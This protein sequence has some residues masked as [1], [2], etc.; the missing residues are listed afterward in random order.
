MA[1]AT[2]APGAASGEAR[3]TVVAEMRKGRPCVSAFDPRV[4]EDDGCA[5]AARPRRQS[6]EPSG[7]HFTARARASHTRTRRADHPKRSKDVAP[8]GCWLEGAAGKQRRIHRYRGG[9]CHRRYRSSRHCAAPAPNAARPSSCRCCDFSWNRD[10]ATG[11]ICIQSRPWRRRAQIGLLMIGRPGLEC[12]L[13]KRSRRYGAPIFCRGRR[14]RRSAENCIFP[15]KSFGKS[16]VR[17]RPSF[18]T[19][20]RSS[21]CPGSARG[22]SNSRGCLTRTRVGRLANG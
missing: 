19:N 7:M 20:A 9:R 4:P 5:P 16:S 13:W 2:E 21:R 17:T 12:L 18:T 6:R 15:G 1:T 22:E 8:G 10:P 11:L 14:S 3:A